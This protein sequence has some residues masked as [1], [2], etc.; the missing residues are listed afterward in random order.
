MTIVYS[1]KLPILMTALALTTRYLPA[2]RFCI[3]STIS[4][5]K[6]KYEQSLEK[7]LVKFRNILINFWGSTI[8]V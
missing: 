3:H 5:T 7:I 8:I 2:A 1:N 4:L 6:N